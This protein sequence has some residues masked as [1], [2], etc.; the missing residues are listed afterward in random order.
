MRLVMYHDVRND[1]VCACVAFAFCG[2]KY[3]TF[4][5]RVLNWGR[6]LVL[7]DILCL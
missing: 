7:E 6:V 3:S 5:S 1:V 2:F 4:L